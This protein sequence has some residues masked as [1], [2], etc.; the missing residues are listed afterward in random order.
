MLDLTL[1]TTME[2][3]MERDNCHMMVGLLVKSYQNGLL[4]TDELI[5]QSAWYERRYLECVERLL[6]DWAWAVKV[7]EGLA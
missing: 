4:T 6:Q 1:A 5:D 7:T 3:Q 2:I